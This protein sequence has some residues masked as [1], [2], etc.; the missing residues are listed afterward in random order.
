M[1]SIY[2]VLPNVTMHE[3]VGN[4]YISIAPHSDPR[5]VNNIRADHFAK[6][7]IKNF[8]D[9]FRRKMFPSV[10]MLDDSAPDHLKKIDAITAFRNILAI[11]TIIKA[12]EHSLTSSFVAYL[13]ISF[14][15]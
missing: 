15:N 11:S 2:F 12:H 14:Q 8:E 5:V 6:A 13:S 3:P 1:W 7:L 4:E 9:Q 10:L